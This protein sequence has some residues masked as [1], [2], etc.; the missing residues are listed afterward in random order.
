MSLINN[1]KKRPLINDKKICNLFFFH[2]TS[3]VNN[4]LF[5]G[6]KVVVWYVLEI[7][8]S[9]GKN[10]NPHEKNHQILSR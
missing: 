7:Y 9:L 1:I 3:L 2:L 4:C 10:I 6:Y 5:D 8:S